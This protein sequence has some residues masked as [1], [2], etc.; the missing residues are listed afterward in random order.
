[1]TRRPDEAGVPGCG[2]DPAGR[3]R[4]VAGE[5]ALLWHRRPAGAAHAE[6]W[7][8]ACPGKGAA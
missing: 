7:L 5:L 8:R 2:T 4:F 1:M 6:T 3:L